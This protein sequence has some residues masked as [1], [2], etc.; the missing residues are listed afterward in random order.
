LSTCPVVAYSIVEDKTEFIQQGINKV[1]RNV[2]HATTISSETLVDLKPTDWLQA[3]LSFEYQRTRQRSGEEG[4]PAQVVGTAGTIY[5]NVMAHSGLVVQPPGGLLRAAVQL[6]YIG[7]RRASENNILLGGRAYTLPAY[8]LLEAKLASPGFHL[9]RG[10]EQEVSFAISGKNLLG[11]SG[12][13]PGFSGVD[14]PLAPR[15]LW[16]QMDLVF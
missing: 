16:L 2:A 6:S 4:F 11:A 9:F 15:A 12:P 7:E 14:Y 1:A 3:Y 13:A 8:W 5:P 10:E